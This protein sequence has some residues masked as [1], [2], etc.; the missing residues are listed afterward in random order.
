MSLY[1]YPQQMLPAA[2]QIVAMTGSS[3][4]IGTLNHVPVKLI[5]DNQSTASTVLSISLNGGQTL[6]P[7]KTFT[8]GEVLVLDG[9]IYMFPKG[10]AF[11]GNGAA[12][13]SFSV[14]YTYINL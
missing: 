10:T 4:A 8:A 2:E 12:S 9:D 3:I 13:G 1:I 5:L 14:S 6:I 7:W 11:Y